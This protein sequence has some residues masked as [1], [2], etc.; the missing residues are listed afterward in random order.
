M[1]KDEYNTIKDPAKGYYKSK[2]SRF[3][4]FAYPVHSGDEA[5]EIVEL[6][7]KEY[8]DARHHCYAYSIGKNREKFRANDDGEPSGS[9]GKPILGQLYSYEVTNTLVVVVRYFGGTLLGVG[10]LISAYRNAAGDAL[11]NATII[12]EYMVSR[13][14]LTF[15]YPIMNDV[16]RIM[17]NK[18]VFIEKQNF[19]ET[20]SLQVAIRESMNETIKNKL[21]IFNELSIELKRARHS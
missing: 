1:E 15:P 19:T 17:D 5:E 11:S 7:R 21:N 6:S 2:G 18:G 12:R 14:V 8:H 3:L 16:M 9:A 13:Y 4:S 10:G 20:C